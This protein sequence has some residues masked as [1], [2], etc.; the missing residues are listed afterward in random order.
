MTSQ[1]LVELRSIDIS[2]IAKSDLADISTLAIDA[3]ENVESKINK[4]TLFLK[5]P[6]CFKCDD[7]KIQIRFVDSDTAL[8]E[9]L[10]NH[11]IGVKN[12]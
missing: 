3:N 2:T 11:F 6:Y 1:E 12:R 9:T 8:D 10:I 7:T 4:I 5:N